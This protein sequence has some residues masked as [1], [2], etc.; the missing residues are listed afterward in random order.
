MPRVG[1]LSGYT[2][3]DR[4]VSRFGGRLGVCIWKLFGTAGSFTVLLGHRWQQKV[5]CGRISLFSLMRSF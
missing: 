5:G 2:F 3:L 4:A 1:I